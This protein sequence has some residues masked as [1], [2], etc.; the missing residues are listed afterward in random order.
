MI[1]VLEP[2]AQ[3][4]L[5]F[6]NVAAAIE[7]VA[8]SK[9]RDKLELS[10][11]ITVERIGRL[12]LLLVENATKHVDPEFA[13]SALWC[14]RSAGHVFHAQDRWKKPTTQSSVV[15]T[16]G[17]IYLFDSRKPHWTTNGASVLVCAG[18][19]FNE[20]V[21]V[22][23]VHQA[24]DQKLQSLDGNW[25]RIL[26]DRKDRAEINHSLEVSEIVG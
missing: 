12:E 18:E 20:G 17:L 23:T 11:T 8:E 26:E 16:P 13:W 19:E 6:H 21:G 5:N 3:M 14:V 24:F 4:S 25:P 15:M 7:G 22:D 2:S 9:F 1:T 10:S